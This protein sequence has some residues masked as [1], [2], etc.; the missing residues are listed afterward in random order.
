MMFF[1]E[2]PVLCSIVIIVS[3]FFTQVLLPKAAI[4]SQSLY[5][6]IAQENLKAVVDQKEVSGTE[7]IGALINR[8]KQFYQLLEESLAKSLNLPKKMKRSIVFNLFSEH[9]KKYGSLSY[10]NVLDEISWKDLELLCG[11]KTTPEL[12]IAYKIDRAS[13][14]AG[15]AALDHKIIQPLSDSD[16]I[17]A[18]QHT[19]KML[20]EHEVFFNAVDGKL[21]ELAQEEDAM[22]SFF[23]EDL[24]HSILLQNLL[25]I[26]GQDS[27]P[28]L[29]KLSHWLNKSELFLE[30]GDLSAHALGIM[31]DVRNAVGAPLLCV[32]GI[33]QAV[34]VT[35]PQLLK[36]YSIGLNLGQISKFIVF[37]S[38]FYAL[39]WAYESKITDGLVNI[40]DGIMGLQQAYWR[41][42]NIK[43]NVIFSNGLHTKLINV[44]T[45]MNNMRHIVKL[46]CQN[47]E[48]AALPMIV[49]LK[50][51]FLQ[52]SQDSDMRHLFDLL[53]TNTF[54]GEASFFAYKGRV[55]SAYKLM[56]ELKH[57]LTPL[58]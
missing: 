12:C 48:L 39:R 46:A 25:T 42:N 15:R 8:E 47:K 10:S 5:E 54:K 1:K 28:P 55:L 18:Q 40:S 14:E 57:K 11:P 31:R 51:A 7:T 24:F 29:K 36:E 16:T 3:C 2:R 27:I 58:I 50:N 52:L 41:R 56:H 20:L 23:G 9:E 6:K 37:G 43:T 45:Y 26:I 44:A 13:T 35:S 30:V 21:K 4:S 33:S 19:V 22:L 17:N 53:S 32:Y 38:F 49:N 34:G